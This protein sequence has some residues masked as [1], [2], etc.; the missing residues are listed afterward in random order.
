MNFQFCARGRKSDRDKSKASIRL[1]V[2]DATRGQTLS[3]LL[4]RRFSTLN[5]KSH[6]PRLEYQRSRNPR[7]RNKQM[8]PL[9]HI[10]LSTPCCIH[11][12]IK[13]IS[14]F[15]CTGWEIVFHFS[16]GLGIGSNGILFHAVTS[17]LPILVNIRCCRVDV[18]VSPCFMDFFFVL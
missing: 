15:I 6:G 11:A 18:I 7:P 12:C 14:D 13:Q 4:A 3:R 9:Q 10:T 8:L 5:E 16:V 2:G 1:N 17:T